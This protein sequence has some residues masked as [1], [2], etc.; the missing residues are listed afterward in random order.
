MKEICLDLGA[1]MRV[2][3]SNTAEKW[4]GIDIRPFEGCITL[5]VGKDKFP[6]ED[7]SVKKIRAVHLLEHLYPEQLFHCVDECWRILKPMGHFEIS[8]PMAGTRA[9]YVHP[10]H[11]IQF[12][13]DTFSFFQ[14]PVDGKDPHG[15]L[16]GFWHVENLKSS[17]PEVVSVIMWPNKP[18]GRH[19]YQPI[20]QEAG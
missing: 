16:K 7:N 20:H 9:F 8:V 15:Y 12:T 17:N 11:K 19:K 5:D 6:F 3:Q 13:K 18:G 4:I 10:D 2:N 14:V 1:G